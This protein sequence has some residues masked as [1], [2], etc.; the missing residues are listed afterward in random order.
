MYNVLG[1]IAYDYHSVLVYFGQVLYGM[2]NPMVGVRSSMIGTC[3]YIRQ[4]VG[5]VGHPS[6]SIVLVAALDTAEN[7]WVVPVE[8]NKKVVV[9]VD[10]D[11]SVV[12]VEG[13][14]KVADV[15]MYLQMHLQRQSV[16]ADIQ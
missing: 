3:D 15:A 7:N 10:D 4:L 14:T 6:D 11:R 5:I 2:V 12:A 8:G 16:A 9:V 1:W 13:D